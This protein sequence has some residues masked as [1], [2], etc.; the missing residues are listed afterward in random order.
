[1][2][3]SH[4]RLCM[5]GLVP[6]LWLGVAACN[7]AT[8]VDPLGIDAAGR[9]KGQLFL[10]LNGSGQPD[11]GDRGA[12]GMRIYLEQPAGGRQASATT[13]TAGRFTFDNVP[14]G[15]WI[16]RLDETQFADTVDAFGV[17]LEAF[18]LPFADSVTLWPGLTYPTYTLAEARA[19]ALARPIFAYGVALNALSSTV[20]DLHIRSGDQ[21]LRITGILGG[22]A[23]PG[24]S[25]RV[26]GRTSREAGEPL[27]TSGAVFPLQ[28]TGLVPEPVAVNTAEA[29]G[30]RNGA[31]DAALVQV[32]VAEILEAGY[33]DN[34]DVRVLVDDGSGE[35]EILYRA[36]LNVDPDDFKPDTVFV[37]RARGLL[38]PYLDGG[39]TRWRLL[40]RARSDVRT[41]TRTFPAAP[42]GGHLKED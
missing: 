1:M 40:P 3:R 21:Y 38:V 24:D 23:Q 35:L 17:G 9:V 37:D 33:T 29:D 12:D 28:T 41:E 4:L 36:F 20:R 18:E 14:V 16:L 15:R 42:A 2:R 34:D 8:D 32:V 27:L 10:D 5:A 13:D 31:L 11:G 22:F 19:L 6:A 26:R 7:D 39:E 30:A 25:V